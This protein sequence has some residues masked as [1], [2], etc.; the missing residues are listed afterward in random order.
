MNLNPNLQPVTATTQQHLD[1][2]DVVDDL[3]IL[4]NGTISLVLETSAVNFDLLS[5]QEQD[6]RI[7]S[8][9]GLLNSLTFH[10]QILIRTQNID[11][12][13]Y[14]SY[15]Q[16]MKEKEVSPVIRNQIS[17][18]MQFVKNLIKDRNVLD[19]KFYVV[20]PQGA[21][22]AV[23]KTSLAKQL[24]GK[25]EKITNVDYV[26]EKAKT[27]IYPKRDHV[28]RQLKRMGVD[29]KQLTSEELVQVFYNVYNP[30]TSP[31]QKMQYKPEDFLSPIVQGPNSNK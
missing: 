6:A 16:R 26:L 4:K 24:F 23:A 10:I 17:I 9:A 2:Y 22:L 3:L 30:G 7:L 28:M 14:V 21:G 11:I 29:S 18:Y 8:F 27:L 25:E 15:L 20:I 13:N 12:S 1:I 31:L 5:E 19:K